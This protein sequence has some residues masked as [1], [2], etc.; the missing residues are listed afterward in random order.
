MAAQ[1]TWMNKF[2]HIFPAPWYECFVVTS[3]SSAYTRINGSTGLQDTGVQFGMTSMPLAV[4][5]GPKLVVRINPFPVFSE[6]TG[7]GGDVTPGS[8]DMSRWNALPLYDFTTADYGFHSSS[9][10]FSA[11]GAFNFYQLNPTSF[12]G[13][14]GLNNANNIPVLFQF[15]AAADAA[16][17][18]RYGFRPFI[19]N[20]PWMFDPTGAAAQNKSLNVQRTILRLTA[21]YVSW[22]HPDPFM[23]NATVTLPLNP[24]V[25]VGSR[26]RYAPFKD[27][28]PW[29]FYIEGF[30]HSFVFGGRSTTTLTLTRGLPSTVYADASD[31]GVL[32]AIM[33]GN[34]QRLNGQYVAGLPA[35]SAPSL[36]FVN[37][38]SQAATFAANLANV[39]VTPQPPSQ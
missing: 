9:V 35:G 10:Q 4:P 19:G 27:G 3:P 31:G 38:Q 37:T 28:V 25:L 7:A 33:V 30:K 17:I 24:A 5:A 13:A 26:F 22:I 12:S 1:E 18:L 39:F 21:N 14:L 29:D 2:M 36:Q 34:A 32:K 15:I 11:N 6:S 8:V 20:T 23:A 16:S